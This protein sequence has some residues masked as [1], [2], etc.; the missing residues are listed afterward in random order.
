MRFEN[1]FFFLNWRK[2]PQS[3][4]LVDARLYVTKFTFFTPGQNRS[5]KFIKKK[6]KIVEIFLQE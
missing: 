5:S 6:K 1:V 4:V 3:P 2:I